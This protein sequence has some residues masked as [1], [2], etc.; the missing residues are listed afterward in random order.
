MYTNTSAA[1]KEL[2]KVFSEG[3]K[4]DNFIKQVAVFITDGKS[5]WPHEQNKKKKYRLRGRSSETAK[6]HR[7]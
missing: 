1:I 5:N 4:L 6:A 7:G 2:S 3:K